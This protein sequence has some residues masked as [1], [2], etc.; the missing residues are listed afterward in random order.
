MDITQ[1]QNLINLILVVGLGSLVSLA[2]GIFAIWK[3]TKIAP[4]ELKGMDLDNEGKEADLA[5]VY[6]GIAQE[7]ALETI[8]IQK[9]LRALEDKSEAQDATIAHQAMII[10]EQTERLDV[11]EAKIEE[12]D[13]IIAVLECKLTNSEQ[14]NKALIEQMQRERITPLTKVN[15]PLQDCEKVKARGNK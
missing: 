1:I 8:E 11:Q 3:S 4:K 12:Q 13:K 6:K 5:K 9:R 10:R 14:Y 7:T 2:T 15:M